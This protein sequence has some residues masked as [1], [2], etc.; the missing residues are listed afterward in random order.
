MTKNKASQRC[1]EQKS[2]LSD[3][4]RKKLYKIVNFFINHEFC[5]DFLKEIKLK[6]NA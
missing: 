6:G 4:V 5:G 1:D 3:E 2:R